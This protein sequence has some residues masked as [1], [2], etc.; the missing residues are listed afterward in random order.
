MRQDNLMPR[1]PHAKE[2]TYTTRQN[3]T[4]QDKRQ[5]KTFCE[6]SRQAKEPSKSC[7][8]LPHR[9]KDKTGKDKDKKK[10]VSATQTKRREKQIYKQKNKQKIRQGKDKTRQ[11]EEKTKQRKDKNK[12]TSFPC[13]SDCKIRSCPSNTKDK[14]RRRQRQKVRQDKDNKTC[15][16]LK[17]VS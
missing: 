8:R 4:R 11:R 2:T 14:T 3:K 5:D 15:Q 1:Q 7:S 17:S 9:D 12:T 16:T 6:H 10:H 13:L